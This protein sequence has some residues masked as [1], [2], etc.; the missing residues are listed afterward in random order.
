MMDKQELLKYANGRVFTGLQAMEYGLIDS[1]G[2]FED[3][4]RIT[5]KMAGIEGEPR[6][7]REKK[8][9]SLFEEFLGSKMED[10]TAIKEKLFEEPI[11]QYK[12]IP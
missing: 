6:L 1:L 10:V 11:L 4:V 7:V 12:F 2:T 3:A 5:S 9:F 8:K